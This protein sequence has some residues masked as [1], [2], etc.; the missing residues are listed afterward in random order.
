MCVCVCVYERGRERVEKY[1]NGLLLALAPWAM[2][3]GIEIDL[4]VVLLPKESR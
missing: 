1:V 2:Q 4:L 3:I